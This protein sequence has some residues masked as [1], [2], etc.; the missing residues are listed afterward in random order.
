LTAFDRRT[1]APFSVLDGAGQAAAPD[2]IVGKVELTRPTRAGAHIEGSLAGLEI[3]FGPVSLL[4]AD[5]DRSDLAAGDAA[6]LSTLW[7]SD[8]QPHTDL[9]AG[10]CL[11]AVDGSCAIEYVIPLSA[12]WWPTSLWQSG[13]FWR[14][15]HF[16]RVPAAL[17]GGK[18]TLAISVPGSG[19]RAPLLTSIDV[20]QPPRT[21]DA[22]SNAQAVPAVLGDV[23]ALV[24]YEVSDAAAGPGDSITVTLVWQARS[25]P[26]DSFHVFVHLL[27]DDGLLMAQSD[28]IP[29]GWT[30]PTT[31]WLEGE[32]LT[33]VHTLD[34]PPDASPGIYHLRTGM[35][36]PGSHRL[37]MPDGE[38]SVAL[39][40]IQV[41]E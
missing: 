37:Q 36:L 25:T 27:D 4:R 17:P 24:G 35:Y 16:L 20:S 14:G 21:F 26:D 41:G 22:P 11:V 23:A 38:D 6:L 30:R 40:D 32:Y 5:L 8:E 2:L 15:Q 18:Y 28:G 13:D 34:V 10:V 3:P 1:L 29:G 33:D 19:E 9:Q 39:S 12:S 31:G 7:R